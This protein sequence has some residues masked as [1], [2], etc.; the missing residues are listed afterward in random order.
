MSRLVGNIGIRIA[1]VGVF[2]VGGFLFRDLLPGA[3]DDLALGDCFEEPTAL[4]TIEEVQH[5]PCTD[6]HDNE[7]IFA[8]NH[9]ARDGSAPLTDTEYEDWVGAN[10][11]P[12]FRAYTG[13]DLM[14]QEALGLGYFVP[15]DEAWQKGNRKV[16]CYAYRMDGTRLSQSVKTS[17]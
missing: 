11:L 5:R 14:G 6:Q 13:V 16:I 15:V 8:G 4:E 12:A 7:V 9:P 2:L 17:G 10:C 1:V 3:A